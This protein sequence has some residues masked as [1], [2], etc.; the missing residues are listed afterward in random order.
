MNARYLLVLALTA[1]AAGCERAKPVKTPE[2]AEALPDLYLPSRFSF[3]SRSG[4]EDAL[5]ITVRTPLKP[6]E[7]GEYYRNLLTR[8][9]WTMESDMKDRE[10]ALTLHATR[11][12]KPPIWVRI[13]PDTAYNATLV[14]VSGAVVKEIKVDSVVGQQIPSA[15]RQMLQ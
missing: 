6:E 12:G 3:V 2:L 8:D 9:P 11:Q 4:S 13:S 5:Q 7:V 10:G 15:G 14:Q 1:T